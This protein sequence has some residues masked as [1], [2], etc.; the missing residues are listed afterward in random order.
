MIVSMLHVK[1]S[2]LLFSFALKILTVKLADILVH[3][4]VHIQVN[5]YIL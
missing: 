1:K 2:F 4:Q 3:I 5:Y